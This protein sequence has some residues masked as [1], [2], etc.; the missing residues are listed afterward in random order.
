MLRLPRLARLVHRAPPIATRGVPADVAG[1]DPHVRRTTTSPRSRDA[2]DDET[3]CVILEPMVFEPP[4]RRLPAQRLRSCATERGALLVFDEMWTGFRC[5]LGGAQERFGV[6]ADLAC[7]SKAIA[8]GMPL[9]VLTGRARRDAAARE[10]RLLLH[11]VRRRGAVAGGGARPR[12]SELRDQTVPAQ[13]E[14][15]GPE[16]QRRATTS[17]RERLGV[18]RSPAASASAAA[19]W[20]RSRPGCRGGRGSA[21]DEV[22]RAAGADPARRALG[23]LPQPVGCA[24]SDADVD[25]LLA[26]YREVLPLLRTALEQGQPGA[27][28]A[29]RAGRAGVSPDDRLQRT[30][31]KLAAARRDVGRRRARGGVIDA[32]QMWRCPYRCERR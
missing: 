8:N 27:S 19:R 17:W 14:R 12:S 20:W 13:L 10:G 25:D 29:R 11:D 22:A 2:L 3:A 18:D 28:A 31:P 9:S 6:T 5:A 26:A 30:K 4:Q 23:G 16:I 7:F 32:R 21:G 15:L 1:A 24:H